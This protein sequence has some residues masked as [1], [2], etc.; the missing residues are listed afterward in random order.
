MYRR[1]C[2]DGSP[3]VHSHGVVECCIWGGGRIFPT[4]Q[5]IEFIVCRGPLHKAPNQVFVYIVINSKIPI[6]CLQHVYLCKRGMSR[7][8]PTPCCSSLV[9]H[10]S[11]NKTIV[12]HKVTIACFVP[13]RKD[14]ATWTV[15][16]SKAADSYAKKRI[17]SSR[18]IKSKE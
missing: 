5:E 1:L 6:S 2:R 7:A 18:K 11:A 14:I 17:C 13:N 3:V 16:I 8:V 9:T 12:H 10:H 15:E 4:A